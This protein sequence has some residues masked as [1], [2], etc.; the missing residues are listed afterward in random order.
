MIGGT[1]AALLAIG[2]AA[3]THDGPGS[4]YGSVT[5]LPPHSASP[6]PTP[7]PTGTQGMSDKAQVKALYLDLMHHYAAA[8]AQPTAKRRRYLKQWLTEP[9]LSQFTRDIASRDK[10]HQRF[11]GVVKPHVFSLSVKGNRA[12]VEDCNDQSHTV[13]RDLRTGKVVLKGKTKPLWIT[14]RLKQTDQGWRI[15]YT[16]AKSASCVGR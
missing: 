1:L 3:C 12:S 8:Q 14:A 2:L 11:E 13:I 5:P 6:T 4:R 7:A 16:N 10:N 9:V 15:Y